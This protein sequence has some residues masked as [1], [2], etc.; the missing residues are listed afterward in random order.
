MNSMVFKK[1]VESYLYAHA[2]V[3]GWTFDPCTLTR[4]RRAQTHAQCGAGRTRA[5]S[6][7][8]YI[9]LYIYIYIRIRTYVRTYMRMSAKL[10]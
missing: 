6:A 3:N 10:D 2:F 5:R 1:S 9:I 8:I 7:Y 4:T